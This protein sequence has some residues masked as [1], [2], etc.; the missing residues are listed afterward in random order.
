VQ[1][2][3][4]KTIT[5]LQLSA[6]IGSKGY[7]INPNVALTGTPTA[8]TAAQSVATAS[9]QI[10]TVAF[11]KAQQAPPPTVSWVVGGTPANG[12][13]LGPVGQALTIT[14]I[15]CAPTVSGDSGAT[16]DVYTAPSG[17]GGTNGTKLTTTSC[18][19]NGTTNADQNLLSSGTPGIPAGNHVYLV[20]SGF[21][22]PPISAGYLSIQVSTQ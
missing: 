10:A 12:V 8:P 14:K 5:P 13:L 9:T 19:P 15:L 16:I 21:P 6:Y 7:L 2:V 18:N 4:L 20:A 1:G 22:T 17:T 11:V 3:P